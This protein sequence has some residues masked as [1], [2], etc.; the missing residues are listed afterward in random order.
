MEEDEHVEKTG[1][2]N[3]WQ[4]RSYPCFHMNN[5]SLSPTLHGPPFPHLFKAHAEESS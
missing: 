4:P 3:A 5:L 2:G 1:R